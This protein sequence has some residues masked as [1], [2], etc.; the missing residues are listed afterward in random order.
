MTLLRIEWE[1][2]D[3]PSASTLSIQCFNGSTMCA[4]DS[5]D[6]CQTKP[7][8]VRI[9][10]F[11][12][13]FEQ[14]DKHLRIESRSIVFENQLCGIILG[15]QFNCESAGGRQVFQFIVEQIGNHAMKQRR[16]GKDSTGPLLCRLT[17]NPLSDMEGS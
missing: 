11:H 14:V 12:A 10:S 5:I 1:R 9:P 2:D 7:M 4:R 13:A 15:P 16:I 3:N 8:P 17:F 6:E